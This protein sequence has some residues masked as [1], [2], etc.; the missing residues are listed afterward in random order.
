MADTV[1]IPVKIRAS[2][3]PEGDHL[4]RLKTPNGFELSGLGLSAAAELLRVLG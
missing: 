4:L 3:E 1:M 2:K